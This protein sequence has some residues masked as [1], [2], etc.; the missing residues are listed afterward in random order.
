[1]ILEINTVNFLYKM[2]LKYKGKYEGIRSLM[3]IGEIPKEEWKSLTYNGTVKYVWLM[4]VWKR[5]P[6][7]KK[8][9]I[10]NIKNYLSL[11]PGLTEEDILGSPYAIQAYVPDPVIGTFEDL[12]KVKKVLNDMGVKLILDFVPNHFS[13]DN[14][15]LSEGI[16]IEVDFEKYKINPDL[17]HIFQQ[18]E[19]FRYIAYG[20]D[21]NFPPWIDTL[22]VNIFCDKTQK[23]LIDILKSIS[24]YADG[25][26]VDMSMLLL[27]NIFYKNWNAFI[28]TENLDNIQEFWELVSNSVDLELIAE[29]Y[30]NTE[31]T[32]LSLGF[33][34]VYDKTFLDGV[35]QMNHR[36]IKKLICKD[37][38]IQ[39]RMVRFLENHDEERIASKISQDNS[40][41]IITLFL[42]CP[43]LKMIYWEQFEGQSIKIPIHLLRYT[44]QY[45]FVPHYSK[46]LSIY[47]E[48]RDLF[49]KGKFAVFKVDNIFD[50]T[51][52]NLISYGYLGYNNFILIV[53]NL[54]GFYSQGIVNIP[55]EGELEIIEL[56]SG[57]VYK[58]NLSSLHVILNSYEVQIFTLNK[59]SKLRS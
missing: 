13:L 56:L 43:G 12:L 7:S 35:Y 52:S 10:R 50:H 14:I 28:Q 4:G 3:K 24:K 48:Y 37:L 54:S 20:K 30:W 40:L 31:E 19:S 17:F 26:R 49:E 16:F 39:K 2:T 55:I 38:S 59:Y 45:K 8:I 42:T 34:Y 36:L 51:A 46:I 32:L 44:D 6:L 27:K 41:P 33:D 47:Q 23:L 22:Q 1:M 15:Y 11:F 25:V 57:R 18:G 9:A 53:T 5:S 58:R 21:P 29:C